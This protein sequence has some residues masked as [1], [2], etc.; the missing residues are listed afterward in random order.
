AVTG[1]KASGEWAMTGEITL[2]GRVL[3][4]GGVKEKLLAAHR[5]SIDRILLPREN[6]KD[7]EKIDADIR[8][9]FELRLMDAV[10]DAL[11]SVLL[12]DAEG[13]A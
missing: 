5:M 9:Q 10:T 7:L 4:I 13:G 12:G 6:E 3:P 8:G 1:R 2:H 11:D